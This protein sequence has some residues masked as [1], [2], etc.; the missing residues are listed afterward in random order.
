MLHFSTDWVVEKKISHDI[1]IQLV[2]SI[3][4]NFNLLFI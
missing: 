1:I 4:Y 2:L 3:E